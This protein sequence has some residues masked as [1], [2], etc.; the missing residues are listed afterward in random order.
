M[1]GSTPPPEQIKR[2]SVA[3]GV[4]VQGDRC[5]LVQNRRRNGATDWSTPGGVIDQGESVLGGL[6]REVLEE[7]GIEVGEWHGPLYR[8]EVDA[9]GFGFHM[10]AE[11]HRALSF[12]GEVVV[13]DPDGVVIGAEFVTLDQASSLLGSA[14]LWVA[15]PL[16]A[17]LL[18]GVMDG[19]LFSYRLEGSSPADRK[20]VRLQ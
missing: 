5:L 8:V 4:V 20:V 6:G 2:W 10:I 18:E 7:T 15:E 12:S 17:H 3:G 1:T 16:L 9:P 14:P 13:D 19:R 11:A